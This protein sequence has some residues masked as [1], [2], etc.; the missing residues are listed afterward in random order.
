MSPKERPLLPDPEMQ[1]TEDLAQAR[2]RLSNL[3][4]YENRSDLCF[5]LRSNRDPSDRDITLSP[6]GR[7]LLLDPEKKDRKTSLKQ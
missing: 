4:H 5:V 1:H 7:T 2:G 6:K 3:A